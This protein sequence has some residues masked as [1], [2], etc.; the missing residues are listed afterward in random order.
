MIPNQKLCVE[1]ANLRESFHC[2]VDESLLRGMLKL[3]K[4]GIPVGCVNG[5]C[6]V[7]KVR[8]LDGCVKSLGPISRAHVTVEDEAQGYTLACRV[9]PITAV[10][11]EVTGRLSKPLSRPSRPA[12]IRHSFSTTSQIKE[13]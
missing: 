12:G 4:K 8:I 10:R 9:T 5:G 13:I 2:A 1:L 11:V 7:C 3:G 6:G